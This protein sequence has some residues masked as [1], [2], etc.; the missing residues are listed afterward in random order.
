MLYRIFVEDF[1]RPTI[2]KIVRKYFYSFTTLEGVGFYEGIQES[3][4][5]I[6]I[7]SNCQEYNVKARIDSIIKELKTKGNQGFV[8]LQVIPISSYIF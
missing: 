4:V 8:L 6:E 3:S 1:D 7:D 5:V 2:V